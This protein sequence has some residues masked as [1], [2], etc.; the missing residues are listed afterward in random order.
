MVNPERE[1]HGVDPD[2]STLNSAIKRRWLR[3]LKA[4]VEEVAVDNQSLAN[5]CH[6]LF[7]ILAGTLGLSTM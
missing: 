4:D 5:D 3:C 6:R 1:S 7:G 2:A